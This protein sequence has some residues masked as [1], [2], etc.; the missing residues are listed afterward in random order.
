MPSQSQSPKSKTPK[1]R[2]RCNKTSRKEVPVGMRQAI[3]SSEGI[4]SSTKEAERWP[5]VSD[6]TVRSIR[7]RAHKRGDRTR[8]GGLRGKPLAD[9]SNCITAR[10]PGDPKKLTKAV[11]DRIVEKVLGIVLSPANTLVFISRRWGLISRSGRS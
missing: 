9:I 11:V 8:S 2:G 1:P 4:R 6:S 3:V 7:Q 5:G 10:R